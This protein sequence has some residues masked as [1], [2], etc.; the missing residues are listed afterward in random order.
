MKLSEHF[1]LGEL[2]KSDTA[3]RLGIDNTPSDAL[4]PTLKNVAH[5]ILEPVR[6]HFGMGFSPNSGYRG[7]A[8]E[9]A[10]CWGGDNFKSSF[11][12]WCGRRSM[13]VNDESW[14]QY[15]IKKQHPTGEA[16]DIELP[17]VSNFK[18]ASWILGNIKFDQLILEFY[19][20]A[21]PHSGWVHC[22]RKLIGA[23]RGEVLRIGKG[24]TRLGLI[25]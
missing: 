18:L 3:L 6:A 5:E 4:I 25:D 15:F 16:V 17:G 2:I 21:V 14:D 11:A 10:I 12:K 8:L 24:G 19:D 13:P 20:P 22:S 7:E 1:S 9:K 23:N